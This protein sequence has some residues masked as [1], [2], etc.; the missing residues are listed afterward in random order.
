VESVK[1]AMAAQFTDISLD[2]ME[3]FLKRAFRALRPM[4]SPQQDR[5]EYVFHLYLSPGVGIRVLSSIRKGE[6]MARGV[7]Q[8]AIRVQLYRFS[9]G[10]VGPLMPGKPPIVKRTQG[11]KSNLR[12]RI[13]DMIEAYDQ[14][15]EDIEAGRYIDWKKVL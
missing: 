8:D 12:Q 15:D 2:D 14:V 9:G 6:E 4:L 1:T 10:R 11:W 13:E 5:G 7:G 3:T